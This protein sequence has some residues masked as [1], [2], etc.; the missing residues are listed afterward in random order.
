M[1]DCINLDGTPYG[2]DCVQVSST[3]D[4][5][6]DMRNEVY[7]Y[8][9]QLEREFGDT[10]VGSMRFRVQWHPHDFGPYA[11]VVLV[12][13]DECEDEIEL[14]NKIEEKLPEFWDE[15]ALERLVKFG[16]K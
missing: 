7:I 3:K 4:Y 11:S 12:Y 9:H 14:V 2:E 13:D 10:L 6:D 15:K 16:L 5:Y 1:I 8:K